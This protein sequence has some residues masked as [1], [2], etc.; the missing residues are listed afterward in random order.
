MTIKNYL[1]LVLLGFF[2]LFLWDAWQRPTP[3]VKPQG[4]FLG[5]SKLAIYEGR[6]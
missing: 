1:H 4:L 2:G 6:K 3:V 5:I